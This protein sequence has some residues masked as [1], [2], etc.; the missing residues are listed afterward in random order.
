MTRQHT[1]ISGKWLVVLII[2]VVLLVAGQQIRNAPDEN[3]I[4]RNEGEAIRAGRR[5]VCHLWDACHV[6]KRVFE[7]VVVEVAASKMSDTLI[8]LSDARARE[9]RRRAERAYTDDAPPVTHPI[10]L[11]DD[12]DV[13]L[14]AFKKV[15]EDFNVVTFVL[16]SIDRP[17]EIAGREKV[18]FSLAMRYIESSDEG[19]LAMLMRKGANLLG[20]RHFGTAGRWVIFDYENNAVGE[21]YA[22]WRWREWANIRAEQKKQQ[23][24]LHRFKEP[25]YL[26]Q[27]LAEVDKRKI[28]L[29]EAS[30]DEMHLQFHEAKAATLTL[31]IEN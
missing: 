10:I 19:L 5:F 8:R 1:G 14:V 20:M 2:G 21:D 6:D 9:D 11:C 4:Y 12:R 3:Q 13:R 28:A 31:D 7:G 23:E 29:Y 17:I 26:Q 22:E 18:T 30:S 25:E 24:Q 16:Y 15:E 27:F